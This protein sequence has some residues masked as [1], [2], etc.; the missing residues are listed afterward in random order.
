MKLKTPNFH[1]EKAETL[2]RE[3]LAALQ[4]ELLPKTVKFVFENNA[5]YKAKLQAGG[6]SDPRDVKSLADLTRLPTMSKT[7]FREQYPLGMLC[8]PKNKIAE[9]DRK[10]VV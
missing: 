7:D 2:P 1:N 8:A 3:E 9:I 10:S 6:V 4:N 5:Y